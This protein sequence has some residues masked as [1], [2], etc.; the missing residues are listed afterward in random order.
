VAGQM[1][2]DMVWFV[3]LKCN[4]EIFECTLDT[5]YR[6]V[7][8]QEGKLN[9]NGIQLILTQCDNATASTTGSRLGR[10]AIYSH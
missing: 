1:V 6:I 5:Q 9:S 10:C 7:R 2:L 4:K 8:Q 3:A